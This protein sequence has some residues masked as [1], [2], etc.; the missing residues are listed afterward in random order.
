MT[1][2]EGKVRYNIAC[3]LCVLIVS[4]VREDFTLLEWK[5]AWFLSLPKIDDNQEVT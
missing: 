3:S 1:E 4:F 5:E 2:A